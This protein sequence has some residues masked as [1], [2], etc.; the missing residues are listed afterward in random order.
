MAYL[1]NKTQ[2]CDLL[3]YSIFVLENK[4]LERPMSKAFMGQMNKHFR[5][6]SKLGAKA[7]P[8][9]PD[10]S[11]RALS[12]ITECIVEHV[13]EDSSCFWLSQRDRKYHFLLGLFHWKHLAFPFI[14]STFT[15]F[16]LFLPPAPLPHT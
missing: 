15:G 16:K 12:E 7:G 10:S 4:T 3:I 14:T 5:L 1:V 6:Q 13:N 8:G 9:S 11:F 2:V